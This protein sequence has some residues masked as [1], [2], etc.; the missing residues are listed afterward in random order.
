MCFCSGRT[1]LGLRYLEA[2]E[3]AVAG[4]ECSLFP[5]R[6]PLRLKGYQEMNLDTLFIGTINIAS[7]TQ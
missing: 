2:G 4:A 5:P 7:L 6:P 1:W 3:V